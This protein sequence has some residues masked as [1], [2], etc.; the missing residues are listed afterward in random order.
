MIPAILQKHLAQPCLKEKKNLITS[1]YTKPEMLEIEKD[2]IDNNLLFLNE[3]GLDP[4]I[5]HMTAMQI[6]D[7]VHQN[8]GK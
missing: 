1:S 2:L 8:G 7:D 4:G 6:I 5:D 3:C